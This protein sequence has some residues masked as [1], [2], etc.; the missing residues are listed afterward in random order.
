MLCIANSN[1]Y[2]GGVKIA[3]EAKTDDGKLDAYL[4]ES[5]SS[6]RFLSVM[7]KLMAGTHTKLRFVKHRLADKITFRGEGLT[8]NL[9][10]E[11]SPASE[12]TLEIIPDGI[13]VLAP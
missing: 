11:L 9:D 12:V 10:G 2:G 3:P 13:T 8:L 6:L 7:P 1:Y 5:V 4:I